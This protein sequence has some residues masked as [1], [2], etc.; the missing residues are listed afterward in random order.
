VKYNQKSDD[1]RKLKNILYKYFVFY[2]SYICVCIYESKSERVSRS[3]V[4]DFL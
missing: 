3:V 2:I 1:K 4:F